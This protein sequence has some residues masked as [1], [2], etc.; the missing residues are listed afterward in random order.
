MVRASERALVLER[1][2]ERVLVL[3]LVPGLVS[4]KPPPCC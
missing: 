1:V 2:L 4:H 3:E